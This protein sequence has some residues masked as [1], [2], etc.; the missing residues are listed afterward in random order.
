MFNMTF[1]S[2]SLR[3]S[4][5]AMSS[6]ALC[7][8]ANVKPVRCASARRSPEAAL[9]TN[10]F[11]AAS[12]LVIIFRLPFSLITTFSRK[13]F[14]NTVA[15]FRVPLGRPCGFPDSPFLNC[16]CTGGFRYPTGQSSGAP[17]LPL[18]ATA[19]LL[20]FTEGAPTLHVDCAL[21]GKGLP[22]TNGKIH[23]RGVDLDA[24]AC[25]A[26]ALRGDQRG[27]ATQE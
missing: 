22:A 24:V 1:W 14:S 11:T 17:G 16:E 10:C 7:S 23:K 25:S 3:T 6:P 21:T 13:V 26:G 4:F 9:L 27:P 15:K 19:H 20:D 2:T 18:S 8:A 12:S 5:E